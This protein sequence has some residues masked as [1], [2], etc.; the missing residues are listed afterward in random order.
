M[1]ILELHVLKKLFA[2]HCWNPSSR[3]QVLHV[4]ITRQHVQNAIQM[5]LA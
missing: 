4:E 3:V 1:T 5:L 2:H